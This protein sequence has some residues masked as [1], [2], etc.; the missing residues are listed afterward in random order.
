MRL[1]QGVGK[2]ILKAEDLDGYLTASD[3]EYLSRMDGLYRQ[4]MVSF[5][6]LATSASASQKHHE[7]E[8]L[9]DLYNRMGLLMQEI[10][11]A[12]PRIQ[13]YSFVSPQETHGEAS[14]LRASF[15][16]RLRR[17]GENEQKLSHRADSG[18]DSRAELC[19]S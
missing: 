13:V 18:R 1:E 15:H 9:I 11:A 17:L 6:I 10:C 19:G 4:A 14:R 3:L 16:A 7:E 8:V 12:E 5:D 2:V